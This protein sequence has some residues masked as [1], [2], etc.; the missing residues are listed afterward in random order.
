VS[1]IEKRDILTLVDDSGLP[2]RRALAQLGLPK[3]TYYRWLKRQAE[4]RLEDKKGGSAIPWNKLRPEEEKHIIIQARASPELSSRQL[5]L[6]I[7]DSH[8]MYVSEST[9]YRILKRE[10]LIKPAKIVGFKAGKEYHRKTKRPNE[11]WSTDCAHLKV[12]EWGWYYLVTVMDDYSRFILSWELK[13][14]MAAY[15]LIDVVQ[16]AVDLTG[17]SDV[18]VEDRTV[19]LSDNGPGYLSR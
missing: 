15:S 4:G 9:V 2:R 14:D 18:L 12:A 3:S 10:G 17:L 19:L 13:N 11:L 7:I 8:G 5:S 16:Q 1:A 6:R